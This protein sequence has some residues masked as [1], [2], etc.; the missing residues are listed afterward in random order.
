MCTFQWRNRT[1]HNFKLNHLA[2]ETFDSSDGF[3]SDN[4][5][6]KIRSCSTQQMENHLLLILNSCKIYL[7]KMLPF[8]W[9]RLYNIKIYLVHHVASSQIVCF[10]WILCRL[11]KRLKALSISTSGIYKINKKKN[12]IRLIKKLTNFLL[13]YFNWVQS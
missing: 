1:K 10:C 13:H 7:P 5:I 4:F 11:C 9:G 2:I 8:Y 3:Q 12:K 6:L